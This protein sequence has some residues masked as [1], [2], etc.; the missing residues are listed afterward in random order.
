ME[1]GV[2]LCVC[3]QI[4]PQAFFQIFLTWTVVEQVCVCVH[5]VPQAFGIIPDIPYTAFRTTQRLLTCSFVGF[6]PTMTVA[7]FNR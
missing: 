7:H 3:V 1:Q 4:V 6:M 2:C 5:T